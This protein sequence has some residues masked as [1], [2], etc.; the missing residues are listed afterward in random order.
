MELR[1]IVNIV[2]KRLKRSR[3]VKKEVWLQEKVLVKEEWQ[4]VKE[5]WVERR[6]NKV[7]ECFLIHF[8]L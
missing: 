6:R 4:A 7:L 1:R 3:L 2:F 8:A 5:E